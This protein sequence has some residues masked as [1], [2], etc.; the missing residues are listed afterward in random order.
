MPHWLHCGKYAYQSDC[1]K[2][3]QRDKD[4]KEFAQEFGH[5]VTLLADW[6]WRGVTDLGGD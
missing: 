1:E 3:K 6:V 4:R 5:D 2:N